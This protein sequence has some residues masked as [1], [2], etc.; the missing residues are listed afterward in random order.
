MPGYHRTARVAMAA[1]INGAQEAKQMKRLI[2][3]AMLAALTACGGGGS[4]QQ[5]PAALSSKPD[6]AGYPDV[7]GSYSFNTG[8][9]SYACTGGNTGTKPPLA[10]SLSITQ[11]ENQL[12]GAGSS[13]QL[14]PSFTIVSLSEATGTVEKTGQ[15]I[16]NQTLVATMTDIP[17]TNTVD[18]EQTGNFSNSG[19]A[20][21]YKYTVANDYL[22]A[23]CTYSTT[24]KGDGIAVKTAK[25]SGAPFFY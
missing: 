5:P 22:K 9:I 12:Y 10:M 23:F 24:F 2:M 19:W 4:D 6:S 14:D 25:K 11:L 16:M 21:K 13:E 15:F 20:G 3:I 17:G 1:T 18:Y 7:A 8:T